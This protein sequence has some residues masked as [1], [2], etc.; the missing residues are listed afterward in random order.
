[1][2]PKDDQRSSREL[3]TRGSAVARESSSAIDRTEMKT[4]VHARVIQLQ[5]VPLEAR[6]VARR[7]V[8]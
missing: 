1:M 2:T 8:K 5:E 4:E 7:R 6:A 3:D